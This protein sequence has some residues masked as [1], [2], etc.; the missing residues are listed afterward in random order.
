MFLAKG[1]GKDSYVRQEEVIKGHEEG[2]HQ[3]S[4]IGLKLLF[5]NAVQMMRLHEEMHHVGHREC[6]A[7]HGG[8]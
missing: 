6:H 5:D 3:G 4:T 1:D 7:A 2:D 8:A